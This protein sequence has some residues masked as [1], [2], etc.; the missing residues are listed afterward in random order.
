MLDIVLFLAI[1]L[2]VVAALFALYSLSALLLMWAWNTLALAVGWSFMFTFWPA[3]AT[4]VL[5]TFVS[6]VF[7]RTT[8]V[9]KK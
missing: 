1:G 8:V 7:N 2:V 3:F 9:Q 5:L 4:V 6:G